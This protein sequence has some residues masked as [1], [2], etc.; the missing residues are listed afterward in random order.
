ML[1][2]EAPQAMGRTLTLAYSG[3]EAQRTPIAFGGFSTQS[4][5]DLASAAQSHGEGG[6]RRSR[7]QSDD[8]G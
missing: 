2:A 1:V 3:S 6:A 8:L 4:R 7:R 5:A